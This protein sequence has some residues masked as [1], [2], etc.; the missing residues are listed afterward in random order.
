L[1]FS[2]VY[3]VEQNCAILPNAPLLASQIRFVSGLSPFELPGDDAPPGRLFQYLNQPA[4]PIG[5]PAPCDRRSA[6][7]GNSCSVAPAH[8]SPSLTDRGEG[9][10][11]AA[12]TATTAVI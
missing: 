6:E 2:L 10:F 1:L 5:W 8:E 11:A 4:L 9:K 7:G 3:M 12:S